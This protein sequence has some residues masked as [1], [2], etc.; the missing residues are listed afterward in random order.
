[1]FSMYLTVK[2]I[3]FP[4]GRPRLNYALELIFHFYI[5]LTP[6]QT[7][8]IF[9]GWG[10]RIVGPPLLMSTS[11]CLTRVSFT[12]ASSRMVNMAWLSNSTVYLCTSI[13]LPLR[14]SYILMMHLWGK[15]VTWRVQIF[16]DYSILQ[17]YFRWRM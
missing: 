2:R 13:V 15:V 7:K 17:Y 12:S 9:L 6:K 3:G 14:K 16:Q 1:M 11:L 10:V 4:S 8:W 5:N